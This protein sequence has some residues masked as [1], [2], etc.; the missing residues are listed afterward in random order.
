MI[1]A[2]K[3]NNKMCVSLEGDPHDLIEEFFSLL[4]HIAKTFMQI[5]RMENKKNL[6]PH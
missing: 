6:R 1:R 2:E 3:E 5:A 4:N